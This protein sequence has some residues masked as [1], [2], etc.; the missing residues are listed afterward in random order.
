M[1][2][3]T[4]G[5]FRAEEYKKLFDV[6]RDK[7]IELRKKRI[8]R[9]QETYRTLFNER[10]KEA[11]TLGLPCFDMPIGDLEDADVE[12]FGFSLLPNGYRVD[13]MTY[14]SFVVRVM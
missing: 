6:E 12:S 11:A 5:W 8:A 1:A 10:A 13:R 4:D 14:R 3:A 2:E 9:W 7:R